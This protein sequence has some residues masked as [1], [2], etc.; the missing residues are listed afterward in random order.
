M[1]ATIAQIPNL[2]R[3]HRIFLEI[4]NV[5]S[6]VIKRAFTKIRAKGFSFDSV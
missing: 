6:A 4:K 3:F 1:G 5:K 2:S